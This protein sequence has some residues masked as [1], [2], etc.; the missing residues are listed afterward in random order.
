MSNSNP[1]FSELWYRVADFRPR[2]SPHLV[3]KRHSY[4]GETWF[5]VGDPAAT[6]FFRFNASA[7]RF[8]GLLDG[9]RSINEAWEVCLA[10]LGDAAPTQRD[11]IDLLAQL[12]QFGLLRGDLPIDPGRLRDKIERIRQE[13]FREYAGNYIFWSIPLINPE[14]IL[15]KFQGVGRVLYGPVGIAAWCVL[16]LAALRVVIPRWEELTSDFNGIIA[17]QNLIVLTASLLGL[18]VLH[19]F[20]HGLACKAFGGRVTEIGLF[21]MIVLPVPYCDATASW[22][23]PS[24]WKRI[25]VA[26]AG[27]MAEMAA[28]SVAAFVWVNTPAGLLH[29]AAFNVMIVASVVTILFNIN[30]LLR[31]D[32]Y[33]VLSDLLEIPNLAPRSYEH[34]KWV[35][36]RYLFGLKGD[37]M[38]PV[39]SRGEAWT[40]LTHA[41]LAFPYR[42][43]VL[44]AIV[45]VIADRYFVVGLVLASVGIV[46]GLGLPLVKGL[47]YVVTE[48]TLERV[49]ARAV[50]VTFGFLT[51]IVLLVGFVPAPARVYAAGVVEAETYESVRAPQDGF[52]E[53]VHVSH[54]ERVKAGA[55]LIDLKNTILAHDLAL[56]RAQVALERAQ[57]DVAMAHSSGD[58]RQAESLLQDAQVQMA[59]DEQAVRELQISASV[60]GTVI[61][62]ELDD[63]IGRFV[64]RGEA[65]LQVANLER[66]VLRAYVDDSDY[67][68][69]HARGGDLTIEARVFGDSGRPVKLE[70]VRAAPAGVSAVRYPSLTQQV[71]GGSVVADPGDSK[72]QRTVRPQW[73]FMLRQRTEEGGVRLAAFHDERETRCFAL[74]MMRATVRFSLPPEPLAKQWWRRFRQMLAARYG[75]V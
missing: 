46:V 43:L 39:Q 1:T 13:K 54:R 11:C 2:L 18:K 56:S 66:L 16:V 22:A 57:R 25:I 70:I 47:I 24:K 17:P 37:S 6:K 52:I 68:W 41:A 4:R 31:Y 44:L 36:R 38:P 73:E 61:G 8:L 20:S 60:E 7:Y 64:K 49:R 12:Q 63:A 33:Y 74:P 14:R 75:E 3:V 45:M 51:A 35:A 21:F 67:A 10:Q 30:P 40:M 29:T 69:L 48:P 65:L 5:V 32:G 55:R 9:K 34:W 15:A 19:E 42:I 28:A 53:A 23:F 71:E 26:L 62:P 27:V 50:A 72:G 59:L 58:R